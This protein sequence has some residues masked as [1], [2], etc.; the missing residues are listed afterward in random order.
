MKI[1][2]TPKPKTT[3]P[4][5]SSQRDKEARKAELREKMPALCDMIDRTV[6]TVMVA[7]SPETLHV[8]FERVGISCY[9]IEEVEQTL[10]ARLEA[11]YLADL[12]KRGKLK[13]RRDIV[14]A[15]W[16]GEELGLLGSDHFVKSLG[17]KLSHH[18]GHHAHGQPSHS[19]KGTKPLTPHPVGAGPSASEGAQ[20]PNHPH[21]AKQTTQN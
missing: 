18:H 19:S 21:A 12:K 6:A 16:S 3:R 11:E 10:V 17:A 8:I 14:F 20:A 7:P 13:L 9:K 2:Q 1:A 5:P 15:A 4:V